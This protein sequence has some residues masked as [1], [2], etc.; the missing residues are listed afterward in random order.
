[1]ALQLQAQNLASY[2]NISSTFT[3]TSYMLQL[4]LVKQRGRHQQ[5]GIHGGKR[6]CIQLPAHTCKYCEKDSEQANKFF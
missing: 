5:G 1:M 2:T 3:F 6:V 4:Q